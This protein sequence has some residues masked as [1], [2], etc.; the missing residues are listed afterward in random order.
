MCTWMEEERT[1][2]SWIWG[3]YIYNQG[4]GYVCI[5]GVLVSL[6][7]LDLNVGSNNGE[8]IHGGCVMCSCVLSVLA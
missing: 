5:I 2:S 1:E 8:F 4:N 3:I 6:L 7:A